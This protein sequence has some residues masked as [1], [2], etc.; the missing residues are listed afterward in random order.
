[1]TPA[2]ILL[3][4]FS[5]VTF[6]NLM[7]RLSDCSFRLHNAMPLQFTKADLKAYK[8][9]L[10]HLD[11]CETVTP[12]Y[13]MQ[14]TAVSSN[15][16]AEI[17]ARS[18]SL[19]LTGQPWGNCGGF[20]GAC[21]PDGLGWFDRLTWKGEDFL[22]SKINAEN[23][24]KLKE[25]FAQPSVEYAIL[26]N[27][28]ITLE[29]KNFVDHTSFDI[30]FTGL[31]T[32]ATEENADSSIFIEDLLFVGDNVQFLKD[33]LEDIYYEAEFNCLNIYEK[34]CLKMHIDFR[35]QELFVHFDTDGEL[36]EI[37]RLAQEPK[38]IVPLFSP[39]SLLTLDTNLAQS[40]PLDVGLVIEA[41]KD[42]MEMLE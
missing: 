20:E 23:Q 5:F 31:G 30:R 26:D 28:I 4:N 19:R 40:G 32:W 22:I 7:Q 11:M 42:F 13:C 2:F 34:D 14:K 36:Q 16:I 33:N 35:T 1:M 25:L 39:R 8:V 3:K 17:L 27:D 29:R 6:K 9:K 18:T 41:V 12:I 24:D 38:Y 10:I 37:C 15:E 21:C